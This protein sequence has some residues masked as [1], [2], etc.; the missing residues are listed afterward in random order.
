MMTTLSFVL[1]SWQMINVDHDSNGMWWHEIYNVKPNFRNLPNPYTIVWSKFVSQ[2]HVT[3]EV[4]RY[5]QTSTRT[6]CHRET[7]LQPLP[8]AHWVSTGSQPSVRSLSFPNPTSTPAQAC[9]SSSGASIMVGSQMCKYQQQNSIPIHT[10]ALQFAC[11]V[12]EAERN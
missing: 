3:L 4:I 7:G 2:C 8:G 5:F 10:W 9:Q 12:A 6:W 1:M 11:W